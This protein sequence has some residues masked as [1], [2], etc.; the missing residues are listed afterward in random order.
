MCTLGKQENRYIREFILFYKKKGVDKIF[1]Y[2]NNNINGERFED[3]IKDYI[4]MGFVDVINWRGK[5]T[6]QLK[7]MNNCY[8]RHYFYYDWL[9]FYDVDE[10]IHL[11]NYSNIKDFLNEKKF[12]RCQLIYLNLIIHTDNGH[13][14]YQNK[15]LFERFKEIVSRKK[16]EGQILEIK[17]ILKGH[18]P[19][20]KIENQHFCTSKLNS[21]NGFGKYNTSFDMYTKEPDYYYYYI[22][23]FFSKS[24]EELIDK[25]KKGDVIYGNYMKLNK[26]E[27]YFN[28][29]KIN[30]K[31]IRL[32]EKRLRLKLT[33]LK[34]KFYSKKNY[35]NYF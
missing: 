11:Q 20:I 33:K 21:C 9:I 23:H 14:Y 18:I 29:S 15:S 8:K 4:D 31:K 2:D 16:P 6:P 12:N 13:I 30:K 7:I 1:L 24:T 22:D 17:F 5:K 35:E 34:K 28:Q 27:R 3:I 10:F 19:D 25:I 26:V 32:I